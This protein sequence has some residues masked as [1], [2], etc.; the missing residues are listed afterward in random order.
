MQTSSKIHE[1]LKKFVLF[2]LWTSMCFHV[3]PV[4][5]PWFQPQNPC[6][7]TVQNA[8]PRSCLPLSPQRRFEDSWR[9]IRPEKG[10]T[11]AKW[12][13]LGGYGWRY[14]E[15]HGV[16]KM[17]WSPRIWASKSYS[18][19]NLGIHLRP[20]FVELPFHK[21]KDGGKRGKGVFKLNRIQLN[22]WTG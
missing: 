17:A 13:N 1:I 11:E 9:S 10:R 20:I 22:L 6:Q 12:P 2:M 3:S 7:G 18:N 19:H 4:F 16:F 15:G 8:R 14:W 5:Q 21:K